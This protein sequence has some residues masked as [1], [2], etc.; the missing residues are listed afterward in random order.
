MD[1]PS[2]PDTGPLLSLRE[3]REVLA[4]EVRAVRAALAE[5]ARDPWLRGYSDSD[6]W[7]RTQ[8]V[9]E[10]DPLPIAAR[11]AAGRGGGHRFDRSAVLAWFG[12]ELER[13]QQAV[14]GDVIQGEGD[15]ATLLTAVGFAREIG[16]SPQ[17]FQ[18]RLADYGVEPARVT[19]GGRRYFRLA[20]LVEALLGSARQDDPDSLSPTDR[21]AHYRAEGRKDSLLLSRRELV[22]TGDAVAVVNALAGLLRDACDLIPDALESRCQLPPE[23]LAVVERELDACRAGIADQ[24]RQLAQRLQDPDAPIV[25]PSGEDD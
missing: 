7:V 9:R 21:D 15:G 1:A 5:G 18:R 25:A 23:A 2:T 12:R 10:V 3:V 20:D 22:T 11:G 16:K 14:A 17:D 4:A 6:H 24:V 19:D 13:R 8:T